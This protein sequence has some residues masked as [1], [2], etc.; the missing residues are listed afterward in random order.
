MFKSF[1]RRFA[2]ILCATFLCGAVVNAASDTTWSGEGESSYTRSMGCSK[3]AKFSYEIKYKNGGYRAELQ[4]PFLWHVVQS[5]SLMKKGSKGTFTRKEGS[6]D[7]YWRGWVKSGK[8][9]VT[10]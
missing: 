8:I 5:G 10:I 3:K 6:K 1:M 2:V 7:A 9:T 4:D